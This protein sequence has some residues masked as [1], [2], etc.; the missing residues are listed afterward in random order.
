M[1]QS[2]AS[3]SPLPPRR[4]HPT[5]LSR[6]PHA[7]GR[8]PANTRP[9][10]AVAAM[11]KLPDV[12]GGKDCVRRRRELPPIV[13]GSFGGS[14][15]AICSCKPLLPLPRSSRLA[16]HTFLTI[17]LPPSPPSPP[18]RRFQRPSRHAQGPGAGGPHR[19]LASRPLGGA[20]DPSGDGNAAVGY[21]LLGLPHRI[22]RLRAPPR[23]WQLAVA[24]LSTRRLD[25]RGGML[26]GLLPAPGRQVY[27]PH[28]MFTTPSLR[29]CCARPWAEES[30]VELAHHSYS[31]KGRIT[32]LARGGKPYDDRA[33][34]GC[35]TY[36]SEGN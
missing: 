6:P 33:G 5:L 19:Q 23:R 11:P 22:G 21:D 8:W 24:A 34:G 4:W 2:H 1:R 16:R 25:C 7:I 9:F 12:D 13:A 3:L 18:P 32:C 28:T 31:H 27:V 36:A 29:A 20:H 17:L 26:C 10:E 14:C 35:V 30:H 15:A